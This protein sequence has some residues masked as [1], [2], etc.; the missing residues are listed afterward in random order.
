MTYHSGFVTLEIEESE[1]IIYFIFEAMTA[2]SDILILVFMP[3]ILYVLFYYLF[4]VCVEETTAG[5]AI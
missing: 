2:N 5:G 4:N 1:S 3:M